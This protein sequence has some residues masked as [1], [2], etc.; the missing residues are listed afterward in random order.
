M[1]SIKITTVIL[2]VAIVQVSAAGFAQKV[3]FKQNNASLT[4]VFKVIKQQTGYGIIWPAA[5][6]DKTRQF[7]VSFKDAPLDQV[8]EKCFKDQPFSYVIEDKVIIIKE[9]SYSERVS[10]LLRSTFVADID[11]SGRV[12]DEDGKP[13][14]KA[15]IKIKDAKRYTLTNNNGD[16]ILN[17]VDEKTILII[18]YLGFETREIPVAKDMGI[19]RLKAADGKLDEISVVSTGY[20]QV[21]KKL[22]TG[23]I[24]QIKAEDLVING[25]NSIE[26]MLQGKL[27]GMA[28]SSSSGELGTRQSVTIRGTSTL[29]GNQQPVWVVDG[30]IQEDPLPFKGTD[31]NA[32]GSSPSNA[33]A[34]KNYIGS[35]ISWLNAY[36]IEDVTILK[37]AASTAIYGVKAANGVIV[38]NTKR[39]KLGNAPTIS[40]N[41]SFSTQQALSYNNMDLMNSE[42]RVD[43]SREIYQKGLVSQFGLDNI[44]YS[45]L[46]NQYLTNKLPYDSFSAG[47]KQ[48]EVNNT[49][50]FKLLFVQPFSQTH[51]LSVSG[52]GNSSTYYGS[53]GYSNQQG[54]AKGNNMDTYLANINF[55]SYITSKLSVSARLSGTYTNTTGF[56]GTDPYQYAT[57]TSRVLPAYNPDGS[58]AYYQSSVQGSNYN[59][60]VLNELANS[61]NFNIKTN[62]NTAISVKYELPLGFRFQSDLGIGFTNTHSESYQS[63]LTNAMAAMRGYEYGQYGP[64]TAQ[65]KASKLPMG[66]MQGLEDDRNTNY[67]FRNALSYATVINK[68][69]AI[70]AMGGLE[71]RSNQY[72]G[73]ASTIYG[74]YPD[75]GKVVINPPA[76]IT[77]TSGVQPNPIYLNNFSFTNSASVARYVSYYVTGVYSYDDR[78]VFNASLRGD[79]SNTFGQDARTRFN[80]IWA[81]GG[82]WNIS[83]EHFFDKNDWLNELS[84]RASYGF[85]GNV[86]ENYGPDLIANIPAG[87]AAISTLT[88]ERVLNITSLPYANLRWEKTQTTNFGL[89]FSLF[90]SRLSGTVDVY[91]KNSSD[92]IVLKSTPYEDGVLQM[93]MNGGT[94]KNSG[95]EAQLMF[96]AI[97]TKDLTWSIS[98]N[99]AKDI[100]KITNPLSPN[101]T[102]NTATSGSYYVQGYPVSG[103]WVFDFA[104]LNPA[105]GQPLFNIPT[106]ASNPNVTTDASA[107]MKYAG[108]LNPDFTGGFGTMVRYKEF[109][110]ST[111]LYASVG[112]S[113]ILAPLYPA[114]MTNNTPNEY[115]NLPAELVNRWQKPGDE[116]FTNIPSL[117]F[118]GVPFVSIPSASA[119]TL[120]PYQMYD[121]STARVV[122]ASYLRINNVNF[123]YMLPQ[124]F[125]KRVYCKSLSIGYTA[126][127]LYTFVSKDLKGIDPEVASGGQPL[128]RTHVVNLSATF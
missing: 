38:I 87:S 68:K 63:D 102:W 14:P 89:D 85:Q 101:P 103:F 80:P 118:Y 25:T 94:M 27:A 45:G 2:I 110:F 124:K 88:G 40:Y 98:I 53:F 78:Y 58:L 62:L 123:S 72:A 96:Y 67:T 12:T 70:S 28:V 127:N 29:L 6:I 69:H 39:G 50:W 56:F 5:A 20:Q 111:N 47:V 95:I 13:L 59:Y 79:A 100:N 33:Q 97:K 84:V 121:F 99:G 17:K 105:N 106:T 57:T 117:P 36:D 66:G 4:Q 61:G 112:A 107:Y 116:A 51:N 71:L 82:K 128:P 43:V 42:Q 22:M 74:Y 32:F 46:L 108:K 37:D 8:L 90:K 41:T 7:D 126:G 125:A 114:S 64:T 10:D 122:N 60:N 19:I 11:V 9:K 75:M 54:Q 34:L 81:V 16:F 104:G 1:M 93:P 76:T 91:N 15:T 86:A 83:R 113:K 109:T 92:L 115:N 49:D 52:G 120:S 55:T 31:L 21:Q 65:Y 24:A 73:S 26:Q 119:L 23:S 30:I 48:L 3:T 44:G 77:T 35:A 18:S